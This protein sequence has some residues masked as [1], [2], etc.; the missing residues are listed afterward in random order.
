[1]IHAHFLKKNSPTGLFFDSPAFAGLDNCPP[2]R[3]YSRT[4]RGVAQ[5]DSALRLGRRGRRFESGHPDS[6]SRSRLPGAVFSFYVWPYQD[7]SSMVDSGDGS[8]RERCTPCVV[9]SLTWSAMYL[10][11]YGMPLSSHQMMTPR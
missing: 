2:D 9:R 4:E 6:L 3:V 5:L 10:E 7:Y 11:E 8:P 1:M